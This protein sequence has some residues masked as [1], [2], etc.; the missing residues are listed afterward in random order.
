MASQVLSGASNPSYKNN[1]GQNV[2]I[3]INFMSSLNR[4]AAASPGALNSET[5]TINWAG[6]SQTY[7]SQ[8]GD[9]LR[10]PVAL[11]AREQR[12]DG[13]IDRDG[14]VPAQP[15]AIGRNLASVS[16]TYSYSTNNYLAGVPDSSNSSPFYSG[17]I[18]P[19]VVSGAGASPISVALA[20]NN[21]SG[22]APLALPTEIML[23][24]NQTFSAV[25]GVYNIVVIP[26]AG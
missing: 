18:T 10:Y 24:P 8:D 21:A 3:V 2:R 25:C 12:R 19:L 6:V 20:A 4:P 22:T 7:F 11:T 23:A 16:V 13:I 9:R 1:T 14:R 26:E 15:V 5:L 17:A